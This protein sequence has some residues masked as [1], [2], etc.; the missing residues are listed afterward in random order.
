MIRRI[1]MTTNPK[2]KK[3]Y[4]KSKYPKLRG[5]KILLTF[6]SELAAEYV[7]ETPVATQGKEASLRRKRQQKILWYV[8]KFEYR[9]VG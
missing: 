4:W 2:E 8:Y 5:W 1:G 9:E 7:G 6:F 3:R